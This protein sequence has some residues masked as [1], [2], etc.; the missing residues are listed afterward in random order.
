LL[1]N[2]KAI[3]IGNNESHDLFVRDYFLQ[4]SPTVWQCHLCLIGSGTI[5][6]SITSVQSSISGGVQFAI[7][8]NYSIILRPYISEYIYKNLWDLALSSGIQV[9]A[10]HGSNSNVLLDTPPR[11]HSAITVG[12]GLTSNVRSY[13][14]G[15]EFYDSTTSNLTEESWATG[16][17]AGKFATLWSSLTSFNVYDVRQLLRRISNNYTSWN[18]NNGYG[19]PDLTLTSLYLSYY[20][21]AQYDVSRYLGDNISSYIL[22]A[23]PPLEININKLGATAISFSWENY[24]QTGFNKTIIKKDNFEIYSGTGNSYTFIWNTLTSGS[25]VFS[26]Y[27]INDNG[28][29]SNSDSYT[30]SSLTGLIGIGNLNYS[31]TGNLINLSADYVYSATAYNIYKNNVLLTSS[32]VFQTIIDN[33]ETYFYYKAIGNGIES[34]TSDKIKINFFPGESLVGINTK[35]TIKIISSYK[36]ENVVLNAVFDKNKDKFIIKKIH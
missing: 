36:N 22:D 3:I 35:D 21:Y 30:L 18:A 6:G 11:L 32:Q 17:V 24:L 9:F 12:G 2:K 14:N 33:I 7:D 4:T 31:R 27:S 20:D 16:V 13:G 25:A 26:F 15:L 8:N 28:S 5:S 1:T 29:T 23:S 10:S 19:K 34:A